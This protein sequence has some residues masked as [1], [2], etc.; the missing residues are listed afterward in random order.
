MLVVTFR[1]PMSAY[2]H[3]IGNGDDDG[4]QGFFSYMLACYLLDG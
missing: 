4:Y 3:L 2:L 1:I